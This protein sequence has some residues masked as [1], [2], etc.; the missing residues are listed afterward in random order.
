MTAKT[1]DFT[2]T[3]AR[4]ERLAGRLPHGRPVASLTVEI[5]NLSPIARRLALGIGTL[6]NADDLS[7][8]YVRSRLSNYELVCRDWD[9]SDYLRPFKRLGKSPSEHCQRVSRILGDGWPGEHP[10]IIWRWDALKDGETPEAYFERH[11]AKMNEGGIIINCALE[12]T[13]MTPTQAFE[14]AQRLGYDVPHVTIRKAMEVGNIETAGQDETGKWT[15]HVKGVV[16]YL[17]NRPK[18]GPKK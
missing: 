3:R 15:A 7:N 10:T 4:F 18:P 14:F 13:W 16:D 12:P 6:E 17:E 1:F 5:D 8:V 11:A 9:L 2:V